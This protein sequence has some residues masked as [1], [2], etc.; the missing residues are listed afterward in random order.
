MVIH[1]RTPDSL[2]SHADRADYRR[3]PHGCDAAQSEAL[4]QHEV[5][6]RRARR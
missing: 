6:W 1:A 5:G 3:E 4:V 2:P